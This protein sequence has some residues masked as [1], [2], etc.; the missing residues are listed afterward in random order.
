M[1][2]KIID[3]TGKV[4]HEGEAKEMEMAFEYLTVPSYILAAR[5]GYKMKDFYALNEK[6]YQ[7]HPYT[8]ELKLIS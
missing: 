4:I 1:N 2:K 7:N 3:S 8:G 5:R 6:Y